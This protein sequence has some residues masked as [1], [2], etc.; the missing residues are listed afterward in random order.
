MLNNIIITL[1]AS[2]KM[3]GPC[4]KLFSHRVT[5]CSKPHKMVGPML[6]G[7]LLQSYNLFRRVTQD[8]R[9]HAL[10]YSL[11]ESHKMVGPMLWGI[12]SQSH[13]RW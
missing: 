8:G 11:T 3:E 1:K 6:Y 5:I 4:Y 9:S 7:I 2:H 13:I 12:L 10:R